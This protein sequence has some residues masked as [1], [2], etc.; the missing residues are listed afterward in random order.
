MY[1]SKRYA[2]ANRFDRRHLTT[3]T[4]TIGLRPGMRVLEVGCGRGHLTNALAARG[5]DV[6]GVDANPYA[7]DGHGSERIRCMSAD[8]LALPDSSF[9]AVISFHMIEHVEDVAAVL[10]EMTRVL[11]PGG[12]LLLVY[13]AEPIR[14]L[15]SIPASIILHGT[16]FR[17][18]QI[19]RHAI[20][21]RRLEPQLEELGLVPR[22]SG[23]QLLSSPQFFTVADKPAVPAPLAA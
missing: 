7:V 4:D 18:R 20:R 6:L 12:T 13:P 9:D 11:A 23:F 3:I 1:T 15:F 19:H 21:P 17:A 10:A 2:E 8:A 5:V 22:D 14:G 16:P